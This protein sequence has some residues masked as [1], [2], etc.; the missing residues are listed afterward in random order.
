MSKTLVG[1]VSFGLG[2]FTEQ[3]IRSVKETVVDHDYDIFVVV[4]KAEDHGTMK[5]LDRE[6]ISYIVHNRNMG[7]PSSIND[8]YDH[9]WIE[10]DYDYVIIM[11]NDVI[12][13][14]YAIDRLIDE[15]EK[16]EYVWVGASQV[17]V[18][19]LLKKFPEC[20]PYFS[21]AHFNIKDFSH[22]CWEKF[23][24]YNSNEGK[25]LGQR[26]DVHNLCLYTKE[27]YDAIG[28]I[29]VNFFPA[30]FSDN[31]YATRGRKANLPMCKITNAYYFHFWSRTIYQGSGGS[32]GRYFSQNSEYYRQK[33]G[34]K[35]SKE[36]YE[37][38]FNGNA[39][40]LAGVKLPPTIKIDDRKDELAIVS[41]WQ[42]KGK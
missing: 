21:G 28:Y 8:I 36:A 6:N 38:P 9:A 7:F 34:G 16:G 23:D 22:R 27:V 10:N 20:K 30:Y 4:G 5:M 12:A 41:H 2:Q 35:F 25:V 33:W 40:G 37:L 17:T 1:I 24:G 42:N 13:Y 15:A 14:P 29:D 3:A 39:Y 31:D 32:T 26:S 11:G 18:Q 19:S